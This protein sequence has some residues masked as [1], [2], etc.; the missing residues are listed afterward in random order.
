MPLVRIDVTGPKSPAHKRSLMAAARAAIIGHLA[1]DD[2]RVMVRV[3]E[4]PAEDVDMPPCRTSRLT[5]VDILLY[6]GRTPEMKAAMAAA[7]R[8]SL[9]QDPGIE[10]SEVVI[11]FQDSSKV[12]L[13]V[14]PGGAGR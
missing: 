5:F 11:H 1:V 7:L 14:I 6:E 2:S 3:V 12:D 13:D 9:A 10:A 4:T 8:D